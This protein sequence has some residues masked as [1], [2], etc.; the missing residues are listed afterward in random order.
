MKSWEPSSWLAT[1]GAKKRVVDVFHTAEPLLAWLNA[2]V[3]P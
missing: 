3:G 1:A 2:N